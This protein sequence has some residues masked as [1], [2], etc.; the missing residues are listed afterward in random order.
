ML[1]LLLFTVHARDISFQLYINDAQNNQPLET[2]SIIP[3]KTVFVDSRGQTYFPKTQNQKI[4]DGIIHLKISIND[5]DFSQ[6]VSFDR[7]N[8]KLHI[9]LLEDELILPMST[10]PISILSKLSDRTIQIK[11]PSIMKINYGERVINF[12]GSTSTANTVD[13]NGTLTA[14]KFVGEGQYIY[15][16]KGGGL[17]DD[18]SLEKL[19]S[20]TCPPNVNRSDCQY[21]EDVLFISND[22]FVGINTK[23]PSMPFDTIGTVFFT[24]GE[25][26]TG[27]ITFPLIQYQSIMA[28]D[29][30]SASFK[31]GYVSRNASVNFSSFSHSTVSIG[32]DISATGRNASVFGGE[33]NTINGD[34]SAIVGGKSNTINGDY[35]VL[36]GSNKDNIFQSY[37]TNVGG[38]NNQVSSNYSVLLRANNN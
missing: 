23:T 36:V 21:G 34:F 17:N 35:S 24:A 18:H 2:S 4:T 7:A 9:Q 20:R 29:H 3:V 15:N 32:K 13:I 5:N 38:R 11:D 26:D 33:F 22:P 30:Q 12:G 31:A 10:V 37:V 1:V 14:T 6:L 16:A 19:F 25:E 28:W 8:L 27:V